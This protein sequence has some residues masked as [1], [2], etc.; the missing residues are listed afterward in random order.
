MMGEEEDPTLETEK[1]QPVMVEEKQDS[2]ASGKPN[3]EHVLRRKECMVGW[4][5]RC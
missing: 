4:V 1:E 3:E 5:T 2:M